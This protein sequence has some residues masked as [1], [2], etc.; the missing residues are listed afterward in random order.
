[1][2]DAGRLEAVKKAFYA[3]YSDTLSSWIKGDTSGDYRK[4]L[5]AMVGLD[6]PEL[7]GEAPMI[8]EEVAKGKVA[9]DMLDSNDAVSFFRLFLFCFFNTCRLYPPLLVVS[10]SLFLRVSRSQFIFDTGF[11]VF[12]WIGKEA[13]ARER[14]QGLHYAQLYLNDAGKPPFTPISRVLEGGE[15]EGAYCPFRG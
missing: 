15:N 5:L 8:F 13:S 7:Y 10:D 4:L 6:M 14:K 1:V 11:Q 2:I 9:R 12:V 3:A